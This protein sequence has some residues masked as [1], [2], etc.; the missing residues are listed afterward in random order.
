[1]YSKYTGIILKKHPLGEA[2]ELVTI[3][4]RETG[5]LRVKAVSSRKIKSRFSGNLQSLNEIEFETAGRLSAANAL[6][7]LISVRGLALNK[8]L[9]ENLKK[10]AYALIG[11]ET[12]YRLT[13]DRQESQDAYL[14][15][16]HFLKELGE[17]S[18]E[19]L[20]LRRFQVQILQVMGFGF[21]M[22]QVSF[23]EGSLDEVR[24]LL[25]DRQLGDI[26]PE[27]EKIIDHFLVD[28]MEREIKSVKFLGSL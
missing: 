25:Q 13:P 10:F 23:N 15:L 21:D 17:N 3:F 28:I 4:T 20:S 19:K 9:R 8:Y 18:L 14:A 24:A 22:P 6:P 5:K 11:A 1:M 16:T 7:I 27:A 26:S 2:D 12:L